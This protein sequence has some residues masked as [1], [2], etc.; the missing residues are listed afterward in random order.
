V[1]QSDR[2]ARSKVVIL[3]PLAEVARG[4]RFWQRTDVRKIPTLAETARMDPTG[5]FP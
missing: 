1:E 2:G 5:K 3:N 4:E